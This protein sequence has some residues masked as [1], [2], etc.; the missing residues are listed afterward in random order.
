MAR[1]KFLLFALVVL[2]LWLMHLYLLSPALSAR[3]VEQASLQ[4]QVAPLALTSRLDERRL[5]IA[6]VA[7]KA[8]A[9]PALVAAL[10]AKPITPNAERLSAVRSAVHQVAPEGM[11]R[12]ML[13]GI[14]SDA[15]AAFARG[16]EELKALD[17]QALARAGTDGATHEIGG[18]I[19]QVYAFPA[20]GGTV[21]IGA[22]LLVDGLIQQVAKDTG[23]GAVAL[24]KGGKVVSSAGPDNSVAEQAIRES[25]AGKSTPVAR[26]YTGG[27]WPIRLPLLT[28]G[29]WLG[30]GAPLYVASRQAL[31]GTPYEAVGIVSVKPFMDALA[32]YQAA[33][34]LGFFGM[35]GLTALWVF[36]IVGLGVREGALKR[37]EDF[38]PVKPPPIPGRAPVLSR[39]LEANPPSNG[40]G[41]PAFSMK[42]P[43]PVES[44][45]E[46]FPFGAPPGAVP[47]M[48]LESTQDSPIPQEEQTIP[49]MGPEGVQETRAYPIRGAA[50]A[51]ASTPSPSRANRIPQMTIPQMTE[52]GFNPDAT[53]VAP[54]P[55][56]LLRESVRVGASRVDL[57]PMN[58]PAPPPSVAS[59]FSPEE[60][61]FQDVYRE[62]VATREKCGEPA[63]GLTFEKF[64]VKLRKNKEQLIQKYNCK[65]VRFQVYVKDGKAAL[66]ATPVKD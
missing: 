11:R 13:V 7:L 12:A 14:V 25:Q 54:V 31:E 16:D 61:H 28:S 1:L 19:Q 26:G 8:A 60:K 32:S 15:G 29:D 34:V 24:L 20:G 33:A 38:A 17:V 22:P 43:P 39:P 47:E 40:V 55:Q 36:V 52:P 44:S 57:K 2:A 51:L 53:R 58:T 66:K 46:D 45:P 21:V 35:L 3:A 5:E 42:A 63:D 56:E 37:G 27:I 64:A 48:A 65:T 10:S 49:P 50:D 62:F 6:R 4:S 30:G 41:A 18:V 23:L 9:S 59:A